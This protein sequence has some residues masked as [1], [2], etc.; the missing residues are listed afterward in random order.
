MGSSTERKPLPLLA[1]SLLA[2]LLAAPFL[3]VDLPPLTDLPQH[4]N[5]GRLLLGEAWRPES[6]Y[7]VN[8]FTPYT[9]TYGLV[10]ATLSVLDPLAATTATM[11]LLCFAWTGAVLLRPKGKIVFTAGTLFALGFFYN[12]SL[13]WG[14][15]HHVFGACFFIAFV[16]L[17]QRP[18]EGRVWW[19]LLYGVAI[20]FAHV[21]WVVFS[22]LF[23]AARFALRPGLRKQSFFAG[24][25]MI[26]GCL[27]M[28]AWLIGAPEQQDPEYGWLLA[29]WERLAPGPLVRAALGGIKH[30][31]EALYLFVAAAYCLALALRSAYLRRAGRGA[32]RVNRA[33]E[34]ENEAD[35]RWDPDL[36]LAAGLCLLWALALPDGNS[37]STLMAIRWMPYACAFLL[38]ATPA[39][40]FRGRPTWNRSALSISALIF[41]ALIATTA[42]QWKKFERVEYAGFMQA[43]QALPERPDL[44][45]LAY[46]QSSE[47][48]HGYPFFHS[49]AYGQLIRGGR[50]HFSFADFPFCPVSHREL[51]HPWTARLEFFPQRVQKTDLK[52]FTHVLIAA[53]DQIHSQVAREH[54]LTPVSASKQRW[55]LYRTPE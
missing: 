37:S 47:Y 12:Q 38:L 49:V 55:R 52:Y 1:A 29:P 4:M 45:G 22:A 3:V 13:Y 54:A 31:V 8:L 26:P 6:P 32:G 14:L 10:V 5:Q 24:L 23:L 35:G 20:F 41:M 46:Y 40:P 7:R 11:V 28:L 21:Y 43:I 18:G 16:R 19:V 44:L 53:P 27:V 9:L 17:L 42:V 48:I 39:V 15:I 33:S 34:H 30:N 2:L 50:I 25:A 36:L 51:P